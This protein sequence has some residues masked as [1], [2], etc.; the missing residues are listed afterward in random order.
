MTAGIGVPSYLGYQPG[1]PL[2]TLAQILNG[3]PPA[4]S[5]PVRVERIP[6]SAYVYSGGGY[7]IVQALIEDVTRL[8]FPQA[9]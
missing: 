2:P 5:P 4:K 9:T 7:E 6:G 3:T 1:S 8:S